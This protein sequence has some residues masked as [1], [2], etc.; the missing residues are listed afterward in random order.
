MMLVFL[1]VHFKDIL[2]RDI[3][4][5][6]KC[7]ISEMDTVYGKKEE[8]KCILTFLLRKNDFFL[9]FVLENRKAET[10]VKKLN[11]IEATI[12][13]ARFMTHFNILLTDYAEEKTIPKFCQRQA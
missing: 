9:G 5:N 12:G 2:I 1:K 3:D 10:V 4:A 6:P 8:S 13:K 11:E 7:R